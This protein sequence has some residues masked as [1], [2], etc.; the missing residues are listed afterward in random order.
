[1][2]YISSSHTDVF[3]NWQDIDNVKI[4]LSR[5]GAIE[6]LNNNYT[7]PS[8]RVDDQQ[9]YNFSYTYVLSG[10]TAND[11]FLLYTPLY[12]NNDI[13]PVEG[14]HFSI[15]KHEQEHEKKAL[16]DF[17]GMPPKSL[18]MVKGNNL[19]DV[20]LGNPLG[21]VVNNISGVNLVDGTENGGPVQSSRGSSGHSLCMYSKPSWL[22]K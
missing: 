19:S 2:A 10:S 22:C 21:D 11:C 9:I 15:Q 7:V 4:E 13:P 20:N 3:L 1:M 5:D 8:T 16:N 17:V 18:Y 12:P 6:L 14:S